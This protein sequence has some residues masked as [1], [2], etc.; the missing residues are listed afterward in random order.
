LN[1]LAFYELGKAYFDL[2]IG[3][4]SD[5]RASESQLRESVWNLKRSLLIN[6]ASSFAHFQLGQSILNL[7]LVSS[8][9]DT[10]SYD[11]FRKAALLAGEDSQIFNEVSR[12]SCRVGPSLPIRKEA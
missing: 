3:N 1:D 11:E 6:P 8:E 4:L 5:T 2:G 12:Y 7:E 10:R 9:N